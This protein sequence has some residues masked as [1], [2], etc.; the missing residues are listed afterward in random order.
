M[1]TNEGDERARAAHVAWMAEQ[2]VE[3]AAA[4]DRLNALLVI[5]PLFADYGPD[6]SYAWVR[7]VLRYSVPRRPEGAPIT[8]ASAMRLDRATGTWTPHAVD[9]PEVPAAVRTYAQMVAAQAN[10][11]DDTERALWQAVSASDDSD[12][13]GVIMLTALDAAVRVVRAGRGWTE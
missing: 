9:D 1:L 3:L 11:D 7:A 13:I 10:G 4:G 12:A 8:R 2:A 6:E 5:R